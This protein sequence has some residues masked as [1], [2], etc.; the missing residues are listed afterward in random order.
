MSLLDH[1]QWRR[2]HR[3]PWWQ[4]NILTLFAALFLL[5]WMR[6]LL[7]IKSGVWLLC[8]VIFFLWLALPMAVPHAARTALDDSGDESGASNEQ[9]TI[10]QKSAVIRIVGLL[11]ILWTLVQLLTNFADIRIR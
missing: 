3:R 5:V 11:L 9:P 10:W 7:E 8:G 1:D 4:W 2:G 6:E